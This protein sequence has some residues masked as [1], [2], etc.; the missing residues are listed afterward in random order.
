WIGRP[1]LL[2]NPPLAKHPRSLMLPEEKFLKADS[3]KQILLGAKDDVVD[4]RETLAFLGRHLQQHE[5]EIKVDPLLGHPIPPELFKEQVA[6][7]FSKI[8]Y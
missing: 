5:L 2:V 1:A 7:F 6:H 4:P 8:C 3:S